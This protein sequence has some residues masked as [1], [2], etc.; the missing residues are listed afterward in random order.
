M[1]TT[2]VDPRKHLSYMWASPPPQAAPLYESFI[3]HHRAR[4]SGARQPSRAR[5]PNS[6][7]CVTIR[8]GIA[9]GCGFPRPQ[10][11]QMA[12]MPETADPADGGTGAFGVTVPGNAHLSP[13]RRHRTA[14]PALEGIE[15]SMVCGA[16]RGVG[17][18]AIRSRVLVRPH[19][20]RRLSDAFLARVVDSRA[21]SAHSPV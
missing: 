7:T 19:G 2:V 6:E 9:R 5:N 13:F 12:G 18:N 4:P 21:I 14:M 3:R 20:F 10:C 15:A 8:M 1:G 11:A 16:F 17:A